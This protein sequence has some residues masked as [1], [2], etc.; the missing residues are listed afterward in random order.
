MDHLQREERA[1]DLA[2]RQRIPAAI[3]RRAPALLGFGVLLT[4]P[5]G[6]R[7]ADEGAAPPDSSVFV[8][9]RPTYAR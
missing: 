4:L 6:A 1:A 2:M 5:G 8:T 7:A 3:F 9:D